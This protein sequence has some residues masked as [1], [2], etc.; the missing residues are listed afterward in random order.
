MLNV[1]LW[2]C[3]SHMFMNGV[4]DDCPANC[5]STFSFVEILSAV[6]TSCHKSTIGKRTQYSFVF[7]IPDNPK[8]WEPVLFNVCKLILS[9]YCG[10]NGKISMCEIAVP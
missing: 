10:H 8:V 9:L 1:P 7:A 6:S 5:L 3:S 2:L 4:E